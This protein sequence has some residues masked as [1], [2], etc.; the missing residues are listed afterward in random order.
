LQQGLLAKDED[1]ASRKA[2]ASGSSFQ[3]LAAGGS[4]MIER[5][6]AD[7]NSCVWRGGRMTFTGAEV[8][9][10]E[11]VLRRKKCMTV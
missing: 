6:S 2:S 10:I 7:D 11:G 5:L 8:A 4:A 3:K 1:Q 9:E